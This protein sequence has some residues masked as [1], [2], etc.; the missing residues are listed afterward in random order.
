MSYESFFHIMSSSSVKDVSVRRVSPCASS[1]MRKLS[2][3]RFLIINTNKVQKICEYWVGSYSSATSYWSSYNMALCQE[4]LHSIYKKHKLLKRIFPKYTIEKSNSILT[5]V[6]QIWALNMGQPHVQYEIQSKKKVT[7]CTELGQS[8]PG[9]H[10]SLRLSFS[11]NLLGTLQQ[12]VV[13]VFSAGNLRLDHAEVLR[14]RHGLCLDCVRLGCRWDQVG[15]MFG[16]VNALG[17]TL[18]CQ[19]L[20][21]E[22][23]C[24]FVLYIFSVDTV[25]VVYMWFDQ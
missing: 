24:E 10:D 2:V 8:G 20:H 15:W 16:A 21:R 18:V 4:Y 13:D 19:S 6:E 11:C 23:K 22:D 3:E 7:R 17:E 1:I 14:I 12:S 5:N 9:L 25:Y